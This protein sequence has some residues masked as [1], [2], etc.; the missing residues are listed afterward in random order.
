M[1]LISALITFSLMTLSSVSFAQTAQPGCLQ[2]QYY[3]KILELYELTNPTE[4]PALRTQLQYVKFQACSGAFRESDSVY[5]QNGEIATSY[6]GRE[7]A[8]WYWPN[9]KIMTSYAL[10]PNASFYYPNG[11]IMTSYFLTKTASYYYA[12]GKILSS[13]IGQP[14]A[15]FY[16]VS[17]QSARSPGFDNNGHLDLIAMIDYVV[18]INGGWSNPPTTCSLTQIKAGVQQAKAFVQSGQN[19]RAISVLTQVESCL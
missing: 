1:K 7:N 12:N 16:L 2:A 9:G 18:G 6:A 4:V 10:R 3:L 19:Q 5:Y 15:A 13:Y 11:K 8:T 14:Q 17:G